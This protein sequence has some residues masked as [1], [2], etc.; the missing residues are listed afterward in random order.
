MKETMNLPG[1]GG[2]LARFAE[3]LGTNVENNRVFIPEEY[4]KGYTAAY[5]LSKHVAMLI[6]NHIL[7]KEIAFKSP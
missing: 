5:V 6:N 3:L 4:G 7:Y 2:V 1:K